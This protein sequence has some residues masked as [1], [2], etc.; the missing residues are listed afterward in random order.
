[1]QNAQRAKL[2]AQVEAGQ[3]KIKDDTKWEVSQE[4]KEAW[5]IGSS[6]QSETRVTHETS[7]V[8]FMF[9][10]EDEAASSSR[11][12]ASAL[13]G[14][15]RFDERG[16]EV[17]PKESEAEDEDEDGDSVDAA[18]LRN[19]RPVAISGFKVPV[20]VGKKEGKKVRTKTAQE[21]IREDAILQSR[22]SSSAPA[23]LDEVKPR[24]SAGFVKPAG[25]DDPSSISARAKKRN[26][27]QDHPNVTRSGSQ[28][29]KRKKKS[30]AS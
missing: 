8:P 9:S 11:S 21:L 23:I 1:M 25:I 3:S 28:S 14:R 30:E 18:A 6:T 12:D 7:Y 2:Q 27:D 10:A 19:R 26:R 16:Q 4:T 17:V 15:R 13:R 20:A 29:S 5:G 22:P 24:A